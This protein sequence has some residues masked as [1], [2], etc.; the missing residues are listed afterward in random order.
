MLSR[1]P[2]QFSATDTVPRSA[3]SPILPAASRTQ[4]S[5]SGSAADLPD[6]PHSRA[7]NVNPAPSTTSRFSGTSLVSTQSPAPMASSSA[8][9]NPSKSDGST[10][11]MALVRSSSRVSPETQSSIRMRSLACFCNS[12]AVFVAV[13]GCAGHHQL[14]IRIDVLKSFD[15]Q[16]AALLRRKS[17]QKQNILSRL[18]SPLQNL[19]RLAPFSQQLRRWAHRTLPSRGLRG[20]VVAEPA[21]PPSSPLGRWPD[22]RSP[23]RSTADASRP[24]FFRCQSRPCTVTAVFFRTSRGRNENSAGPSA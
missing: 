14:H 5:R 7:R 11:I 18:E 6:R 10:K 17:S 12:R 15:Q 23:S 24:H 21:K 2:R 3:S 19:P 22:A 4:D 13:T 1:C 16:M 20:N 8:S 9:D